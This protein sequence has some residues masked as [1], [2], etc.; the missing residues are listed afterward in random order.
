MK[1]RWKKN[2]RIKLRI[3]KNEKMIY[4]KKI[5]LLIKVINYDLQS[6]SLKSSS[7]LLPSSSSS[8]SS[9]LS[10]LLKEPKL[11][12]GQKLDLG[13]KKRENIWNS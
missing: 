12:S 2:K 13:K 1:S 10:S 3:K 8:S 9:S 7:F 11:F 4:I 6:I 5:F